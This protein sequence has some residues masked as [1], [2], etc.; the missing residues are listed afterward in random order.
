MTYQFNKN[1][2]QSARVN[3]PG[4]GIWMAEVAT[5]EGKVYKTGDPVSLVLSDLVMAGTVVTGGEYV[6]SAS[7]VVIGG[8]GKWSSQVKRRAY[9]TDSGVRLSE[10]VR[11][12]AQ[13]IGERIFLEPGVD[14]TLG[15]AWE[16]LAGLASSALR[17]VVGSAWWV[18]ADG[19]TH[20]GPRP[21]AIIPSST[22]IVLGNF[23]PMFRRASISL[24]D[25]KLAA[26]APGATFSVENLPAGFL[27]S[28]SLIFVRS[29]HVRLELLG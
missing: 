29:S 22:K 14:R 15:Y 16:R 11:D 8:S 7:Y 6:G 9:R 21:A 2:I 4:S 3:I 27:I 19:V 12:L 26:F 25:D 23:D 28:T 13:E 18:A 24:P 5:T 20:I 1:D 10:V 17:D